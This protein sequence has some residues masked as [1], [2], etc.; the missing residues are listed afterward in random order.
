MGLSQKARHPCLE[1]TR[2]RCS[3]T[4]KTALKLAQNEPFSLGNRNFPSCRLYE[5]G[6][7]VSGPNPSF[8]VHKARNNRML[9][10]PFV[11]RENDVHF[12]YPSCSER[13]RLLHGNTPQ[14]K[15]DSAKQARDSRP[16]ASMKRTSTILIP[17]HPRH[18]NTPSLSPPRIEQNSPFQVRTET[19]PKKRGEH[20]C[21]KLRRKSP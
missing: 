14:N 7:G 19:S 2:D 21:K 12:P 8:Q 11:A 10:H 20:I 6:E 1:G 5:E 13:T 3:Q 18:E 16:R 15:P 17:I 9:G 4:A